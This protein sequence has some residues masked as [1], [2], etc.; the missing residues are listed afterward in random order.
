ML[1]RNDYII[2]FHW[3][4]TVCVCIRNDRH[5]NFHFSNLEQNTKVLTELYSMGEKISK[6]PKLQ[7]SVTDQAKQTGEKSILWWPYS[8]QTLCSRRGLKYYA[9]LKFNEFWVQPNP[10]LLICDSLVPSSQVHSFNWAKTCSAYTECIDHFTLIV[11]LMFIKHLLPNYSMSK[12][13]QL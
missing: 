5:L 4:V 12:T 7:C 1:G 6:R 13:N 8:S 3:S 10:K 11:K 9:P 2:L